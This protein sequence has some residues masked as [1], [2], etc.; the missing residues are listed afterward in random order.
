MGVAEGGCLRNLGQSGRSNQNVLID[1]LRRLFRIV[2]TLWTY[3]TFSENI[4]L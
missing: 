2:A 4:D 3:E 1:C